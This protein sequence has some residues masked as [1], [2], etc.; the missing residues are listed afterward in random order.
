MNN[1]WIS[2]KTK[3]NDGSVD[4]TTFSNQCMLISIVDYLNQNGILN[5]DS[6]K[7]TVSN[8]RNK[9]VNE[10]K[11]NIEWGENEMFDKNK[12]HE[13]II[14]DIA[15]FYDLEINVYYANIIDGEY[16]YMPSGY[17]YTYG[18]GRNK[19]IIIAYGG[20]FELL[21]DIGEDFIPKV[22]V[23]DKGEIKLK[24]ISNNNDKINSIVIEI[25]NN[26][27]EIKKNTELGS[28]S[29]VQDIHK[30]IN[31]NNKL[32]KT[33]IYLRLLLNAYLEIF[34]I[35]I[36]DCDK[37]I[38]LRNEINSLKSSR[39]TIINLEGGSFNYKHKYIT[40]KNKYLKL[41]KK[42]FN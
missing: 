11:D 17:K 36:N 24:E 38:K 4:G 33:N 12:G 34:T 41:K 31:S 32:I 29:D 40:W 22:Y 5:N 23:E 15:N 6:S 27:K 42:L 7:V 8:L 18:N 35:N 28:N 13:Q 16:K 25:E 10:R 3:S 20:H 26:E 37:F 19:F 2:F 1:K 30:Y 21:D 14:I 9:F 39:E